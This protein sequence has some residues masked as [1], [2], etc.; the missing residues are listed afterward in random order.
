MTGNKMHG[1]VQKPKTQETDNHQGGFTLVELLVV[2]AIIGFIAAIATPQVTK[3]LGAAKID[4][5]KAQMKNLESALELYYLDT[6]NYPSDDQGLL[7]L[8]K[9][10]DGVSAWNGPYLKKGGSLKDGWGRSYVY[11]SPVTEKPYEILS[12]G[13]DGK[14]GGTGEDADLRSE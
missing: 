5:T 9:Q 10:P 1:T 3:Y 14:E 11:K 12:F 8:E 13:R 4:T 7:A 2:L 6:G